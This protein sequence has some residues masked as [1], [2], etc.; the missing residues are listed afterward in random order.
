[1]SNYSLLLF[2]AMNLDSTED[3]GT[4]EPSSALLELA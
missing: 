4:P 3:S 2:R 1:M